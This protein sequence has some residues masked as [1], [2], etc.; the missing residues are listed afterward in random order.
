[1]SEKEQDSQSLLELFK[2]RIFSPIMSGFIIS[3]LVIN[4]EIPYA[5][6]FL[7]AEDIEPINKVGYIKFIIKT[8]DHPQCNLFWFPLLFSIGFT[9][10]S[11]IIK[12]GT[13][14]YIEWIKKKYILYTERLENNYFRLKDRNERLEE[15][16][17]RIKQEFI[18][19]LLL[20]KKI[21]FEEFMEGDWRIFFN[22]N[23]DYKE[24]Y[25][26]FYRD[27]KFYA[28]EGSKFLFECVYVGYDDPQKAVLLEVK[29]RFDKG[30][31]GRYI[32]RLIDRENLQFNSFTQGGHD[33]IL[34]RMSYPN[35]QYSGINI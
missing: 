14:Y 3:W 30:Y 32:L 27:N 25:S 2:T 19:L 28:R 10:I 26:V 9:L 6:L 12:Y 11:P 34:Q 13:D 20:S 35:N 18:S 31:E 15:S 8:Y 23:N 17:K 29:G 5:T 4:W 16:S 22:M 1:M 24:Y 21:S 33:I 7:S